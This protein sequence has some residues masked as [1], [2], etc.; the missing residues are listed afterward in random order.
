[1][2]D[3]ANDLLEILAKAHQLDDDDVKLIPY[4]IVSIRPLHERA[5]DGGSGE[6]VVAERLTEDAFLSLI[7]GK[8]LQSDSGKK[9]DREDKQYLRVHFEVVHRWAREPRRFREQ[10]LDILRGL[11]HQIGGPRG[12]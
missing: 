1:M 11:S 4:T 10:R 3:A 7:I 12:G 8:Y 6:E 9:L 5:V 2:P